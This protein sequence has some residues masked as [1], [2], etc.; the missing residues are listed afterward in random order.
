MYTDTEESI[1]QADIEMKRP[2]SRQQMLERS[3]NIR[4]R[5]VAAGLIDSSLIFLVTYLFWK[6]ARIPVPVAM[7][8]LPFGLL[9]MHVMLLLKDSIEGKSPGKLLMRLTT[10]ELRTGRP[11][12]FMAGVVRNWWLAVPLI[13]PT[14]M[15]ALAGMQVVG[16][17]RQRLG[18][19]GAGTVVVRDGGDEVDDD[20][21]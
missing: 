5:R 2:L 3:S 17:K 11:A 6:K 18:D 20:L 14:L 15:V 8:R 13:G 9:V 19:R 1:K 10:L 7:L 4:L 12:G 16:G 21:R